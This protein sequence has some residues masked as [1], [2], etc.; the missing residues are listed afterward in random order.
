MT[1]RLLGNFHQYLIYP[2]FSAIKLGIS[3]RLSVNMYLQARWEVSGLRNNVYCNYPE[4]CRQM[5]NCISTILLFW[6]AV[7][8][9]KSSIYRPQF[10]FIVMTKRWCYSFCHAQ[11]K[12]SSFEDRRC[13]NK[14][15]VFSYISSTWRA[16]H[17]LSNTIEFSRWWPL[18]LQKNTK[19]SI[20]T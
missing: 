19:H 15:D 13:V 10:D 11:M 20:I 2:W 18:V 3:H 4:P 1:L 12:L 16:A 17:I 8:H 14:W 9:R 5:E 6:H 7:Y